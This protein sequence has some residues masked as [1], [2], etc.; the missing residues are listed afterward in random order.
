MA[1]RLAALPAQLSRPSSFQ[2]YPRGSFKFQRA[3][4]RTKWDPTRFGVFAFRVISDPSFPRRF[5]GQHHA[6]PKAGEF[7]RETTSL[8]K[9]QD[10]SEQLA[11]FH[12]STGFKRNGGVPP[13]FHII[14]AFGKLAEICGQY[15]TKGRLCYVEGSIRSGKYEDREGNERK[16]YDIIARQMRMLSSSNGNGAKGKTE[17]RS[18][19]TQASAEDNPFE[20]EN[21]QGNDIPF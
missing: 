6:V 18:P 19:A 10:R 8:S 15:L 4:S 5:G 20:H 11:G 9:Q 2:S 17:D 12:A 3:A 7:Y 16:S 14:V 21:G 1:I 13:I